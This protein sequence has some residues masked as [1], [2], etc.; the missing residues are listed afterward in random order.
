M[1]S[2]YSDIIKIL[3]DKSLLCLL[4]KKNVIEVPLLVLGLAGI[5]QM[6]EVTFRL[7]WFVYPS[8]SQSL[9]VAAIQVYVQYVRRLTSLRKEE[10][11]MGRQE[12]R[13]NKL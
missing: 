2:Q 7:Y 3:V 11:D 13:I 5:S 1:L 10:E 9:L 4:H 6:N 8:P 12:W